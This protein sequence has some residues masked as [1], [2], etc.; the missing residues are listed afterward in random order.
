MVN[1]LNRFYSFCF[2]III[3]KIYPIEYVAAQWQLGVS[4]ESSL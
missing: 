3:L 4:L 1:W 2:P